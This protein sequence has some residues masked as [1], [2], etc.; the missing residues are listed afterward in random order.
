VQRM[1]FPAIAILASTIC[2]PL[3]AEA[4]EQSAALA[5]LKSE[6]VEIVKQFASTLKPQLKQAMQTG[7]PVLAINVCSVQAP[8]I[9]ESLSID[10]GWTVNR[11]SLKPRNS[12]SAVADAWETSVLQQ[13]NSRQQAGEQANKLIHAEV[14]E[15]QYRLMKAQPVEPLCL[16][17]HGQ[18][19][20]AEVT[21]ALGEHYAK[22]QATGYTLGQ[23]RGAIS[24][25]KQL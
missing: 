19:L 12:H 20:S 24:L 3:E 16:T 11:V 9:A 2:L 25:R 8:A 17:C 4:R 7:G 13:F 18:D 10:T 5:Q 21:N 14:V 23:V 6:A 22:D 1:S 15:D